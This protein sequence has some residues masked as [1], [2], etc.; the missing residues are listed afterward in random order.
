LKIAETTSP[1]WLLETLSTFNLSPDFVELIRIVS[2]WSDGG[3]DWTD[4]W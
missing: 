1:V 3:P 2:L 4:L